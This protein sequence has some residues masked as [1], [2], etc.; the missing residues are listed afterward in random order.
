V[1]RSRIIFCGSGKAPAENFDAVLAA[2][3]H[4]LLY[5]KLKFFKE[6]KVKHT[7]KFDILFF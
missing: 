2:P 4:A 7:V 3:A 6:I 1:L 5:S